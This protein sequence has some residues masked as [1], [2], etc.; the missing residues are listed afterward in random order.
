MTEQN[1]EQRNRIVEH[2]Q[3]VATINELVG[4]K[5]IINEI[6][7]TIRDQERPYIVYLEGMGGSGKTFLLRHA[8]K[9]ARGMAGVR[10]ASPLVDL[11][12]TQVS[13]VAGLVDELCLA[14]SPERQ[15]F[16]KYR[17]AIAKLEEALS[18]APDQSKQVQALREE[19]A[20]AF[21]DDY[22]EL[23]KR[24]RIL[25]AL[26][27]TEKLAL[28]ESP[29]SGDLAV[30]TKLDT[31]DW[32][33]DQFLPRLTNSVIL[34]A[35]RPSKGR[36]TLSI[37]LPSIGPEYIKHDELRGFNEEEA[38]DYFSAEVATLKEL[39][40][41]RAAA[42]IDNLTE[43]DRQAIFY[44]LCDEGAPPNVPPILL[45]M[46]ID[47]VV[48]AQKSAPSLL[49][50]PEQARALTAE[51]RQQI[52]QD[53]TASIVTKLQEEHGP[54]DKIVT[55]L[56]QLRKGATV[57][58]LSDLMDEPKAWIE[59][60]FETLD[61]ISFIKRRES[62]DEK[63]YFLHDEV[64]AM[65]QKHG[66]DEGPALERLYTRLKTYY[67]DQ[68]KDL[69]TK[70]DNLYVPQAEGHEIRDARR[71]VKAQRELREAIINDVHYRLRERAADGFQRYFH[72]AENA[73]GANDD[74]LGSMLRTEM[75]AFRLEVG[76][77]ASGDTYDGLS[78]DDILADEA[79][80]WIAW[81]WTRAEYKKALVVA[82]QLKGTTEEPHENLKR[83]IDK[84]DLL[85]KAALDSW[86]GLQLVEDGKITQGQSLIEKA[87]E[88]LH[89]PQREDRWLG[90]LANA[91]N[92]LGYTF[93]QQGRSHPAIDA[94]QKAIRLWRPLGFVDAL[95]R[96]LN[97]QAFA[98]ALIGD[99]DRARRIG[100]E[101]Q[102]LRESQGPSLASGLSKNTRAEIEIRANNPNDAII[103]AEAALDLFTALE[104][105]RERGMAL[106]ALAEAER[107]ASYSFTNR[108]LQRT[109]AL[110]DQAETHAADAIEAYKRSG[111]SPARLAEAY[112]EQGCLCRARFR[113]DASAQKQSYF[114]QAE[115]SLQKAVKIAQESD[116]IQLQLDAM[117]NLL[118]L[119]THRALQDQEDEG[120]DLHSLGDNLAKQIEALV[121][122]E[123]FYRSADSA[124]A[125]IAE[126][127][128]PV[129]DAYYIRLGDWEAL[130]G[131]IAFQ[132]F[133][134]SG[135]E[136]DDALGSA[137]TYFTLSLEYHRAY[138]PHLFW[139]MRRNRKR[140]HKH[141]VEVP[142]AKARIVFETVDS[143]TQEYG[144]PHAYLV[145]YL[146]ENFGTLEDYLLFVD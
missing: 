76:L 120:I 137:M 15:E 97:N 53:L 98:L 28:Q 63:R 49:R 110:L 122:A 138:S 99:F 16:P 123:Y 119:Y 86:H 141:I 4:R 38:I 35:G 74:L 91:Y 44:S 30:E 17:A 108:Q 80:R 29:I 8:L 107:R 101:A 48:I 127:T 71:L 56:S 140:I 60:A 21:L 19:A 105:E 135:D 1:P 96:S 68:I 142:H 92:W 75:R 13:T 58:L 111:S 124:D 82:E 61:H 9:N 33:L 6:L 134:Q 94:Y 18:S 87:I 32:L 129:R 22:S 88:Q 112:I 146:R 106:R 116:L 128:K 79:V 118:W 73:V 100:Q 143:V 125:P 126:G 85:A 121:P 31:L 57:D 144:L 41:E 3:G 114:E 34:L 84:G 83:I 67:G 7:S 81:L 23:E 10:V 139:Q 42:T 72:H 36:R 27:T 131:E 46:T 12:H 64:Y 55:T 11:Y 95:A 113:Q 47:H 109:E 54:Y 2:Y 50:S 24:E 66:D 132:Q 115:K 89:P 117:I 130:Q 59:K 145:N 136:D 104:S 40:E 20:N 45:A 69:R 25:L 65:L 93:N 37:E 90:I 62:R 51:E 43:D 78:F 5:D 26:D 77:L 52:R 14:L 103:H 39:N 133:V 70:I 102:H